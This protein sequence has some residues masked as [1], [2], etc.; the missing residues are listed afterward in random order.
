M[1]KIEESAPT[2]IGWIFDARGFLALG[3]V[4]VFVIAFL[5]LAIYTWIDVFKEAA[6]KEK[7]P[8]KSTS[9]A[10]FVFFNVVLLI[11]AFGIWAFL[12]GY[13]KTALLCMVNRA[14]F[15]GG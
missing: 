6:R 4:A 15:A 12:V 7:G 2:L 10:A 1:E 9:M 8:F 3:A 5:A 11:F 14:G 13:W